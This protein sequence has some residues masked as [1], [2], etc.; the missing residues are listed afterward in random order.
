MIDPKITLETDF[1]EDENNDEV[2][3]SSFENL[4]F[5]PSEDEEDCTIE[6]TIALN[7]FLEDF[8]KEM[9]NNK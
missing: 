2:D 1:A 5:Q 9:K 6:D 4:F 8:A 7:Q 3:Y